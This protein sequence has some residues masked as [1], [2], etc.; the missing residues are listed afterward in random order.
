MRG[1]LIGNSANRRT[2]RGILRFVTSWLAKEQDK[3][4]RVNTPH[5]SGSYTSPAPPPVNAAP[6]PA[7][8]FPADLNR[9]TGPK[10]WSAI[11]ELVRKR[12]DAHSFQTWIRPLKGIGV[13]KGTL[14]VNMPLDDFEIVNERWGEQITGAA[15]SL[16]LS[17]VQFVVGGSDG[18]GYLG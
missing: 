9:N 18:P 16:G 11:A 5:G 12:I 2:A 1:W 4:P 13:S 15:Q 17:A 6:K 8:T 10:A 3:A 7:V 14:Y